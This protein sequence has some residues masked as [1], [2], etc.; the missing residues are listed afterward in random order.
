MLRL[1]LNWKKKNEVDLGHNRYKR[2][3][4]F[5]Q[6]KIYLQGLV[7]IDHIIEDLEHLG[8]SWSFYV[9]NGLIA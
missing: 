3:D 4:G 9:S 1:P 6:R 5:G 8:K 2:K 7:D